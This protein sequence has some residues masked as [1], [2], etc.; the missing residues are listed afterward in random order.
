MSIR[1]NILYACLKKSP[2]NREKDKGFPAVLSGKRYHWLNKDSTLC[3]Q[4]HTHDDNFRQNLAIFAGLN[5]RRA[6]PKGPFFAS[7]IIPLYGTEQNRGT[8]LEKAK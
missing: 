7:A 6:V 4:R 1:N 8:L 2:A 3:E 5:E